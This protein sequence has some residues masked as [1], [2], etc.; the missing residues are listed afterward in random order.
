[1]TDT[2]TA[3]TTWVVTVRGTGEKQDGG[4]NM[5]DLVVRELNQPHVH[6]DLNYPAAISFANAQ[7]NLFGVS[8]DRSIH[9]GVEE[10][11]Q[12]IQR[13]TP[14]DRF[15][16]LGYSLGAIIVSLLLETAE[17]VLLS[18]IIG[19]GCI[20]N[21]MRRKTESYGIT[22]GGYGLF[23]E[24]FLPRKKVPF[25][26]IASPQD[27]I[28]S[29]RQDSILRPFVAEILAFSV[30]APGP[31]AQKFFSDLLIG[32]NN[33]PPQAIWDGRLGQMLKDARGYLSGEHT[34]AYG[35]KLWYDPINGVRAP[36]PNYSGIEL[37]ALATDRMI[38]SDAAGRN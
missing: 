8:G 4:Q 28:T 21:P 13:S 11:R 37:L 29:S 2:N 23:R 31:A 19:A 14:T 6:L 7:Q 34:I 25:V 35:R 30:A 17:E 24:R 33:I 12:V 26:E 16:L 27:M 36:G 32:K 3:I 5:L 9:L 20:A 15:V 10:L 18:K 1:M 22:A 38:Q